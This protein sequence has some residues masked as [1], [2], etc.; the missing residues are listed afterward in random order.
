[1]L[2]PNKKLAI[3]YNGLYW[4]S[5]LHRVDSYH[6]NKTLECRKQGIDLIHIFEDEWMFKKE[7]VKSILKSKLGVFDKIIY[8][9]KCEIKE[10][11]VTDSR[12]FLDN[13]HIQGNVNSKVKIGLY[14]DNELVSLMTFGGLRVSM[15]SKSEDGSY[16][17]YR[18]ANKLNISVIGGFSKLL[19]YFIKTYNPKSILTFSDNRYFTGEIYKSNNF[20][21]ISETK[22]NYFYI[23]KHKRENRFKYRKDILVSEGYDKD[24]SER[25]IMKERGINRIYD[26]GNKKWLL[27]L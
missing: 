21:F 2:I 18:F 8:G 15:G 11:N 27:K 20:S 4:H 23:I 13:N 17:M 10:V 5:D 25:Q 1:M 24:K 14:Y 7:I 16:E 22:P 6:L 3:E 19:K 12:I 9:R 26:C